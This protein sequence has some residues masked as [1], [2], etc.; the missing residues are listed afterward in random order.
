VGGRHYD[1]IGNFKVERESIKGTSIS[2]CLG[3]QMMLL[4]DESGAA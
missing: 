2:C 1:G 3:S 4:D